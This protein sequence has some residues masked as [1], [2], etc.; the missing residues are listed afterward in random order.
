MANL[1]SFYEQQLVYAGDEEGLRPYNLSK[2]LWAFVGSTV[3]KSDK[4]RSDILTVVRFLHR[5]LSDLGW[6]T[7]T[8]GRLLRGESGITDPASDR[9]IFAE[10]FRFSP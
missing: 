5:A 7:A 2:P 1:L 3:N 8:I 6:A 4:R 9:D 10:R